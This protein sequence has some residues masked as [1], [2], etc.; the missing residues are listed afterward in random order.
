VYP[1]EYKYN[2]IRLVC[3]EFGWLYEFFIY[4]I[5]DIS[6]L[7][8]YNHIQIHGTKLLA[9]DKLDMISYSII[10]QKPKCYPLTNLPPANNDHLV[11]FE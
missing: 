5:K 3:T 9:F 6:P 10:Y 2:I 11:E 4:F 8:L 1:L 7:I